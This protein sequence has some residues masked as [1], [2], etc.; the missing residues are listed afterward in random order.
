MLIT[1]CQSLVR[2]LADE[3]GFSVKDKRSNSVKIGDLRIN[4]KSTFTSLKS[5]EATLYSIANK[6]LKEKNQEKICSAAGMHML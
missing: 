1:P 6:K 2:D 5:L 3:G 4:I